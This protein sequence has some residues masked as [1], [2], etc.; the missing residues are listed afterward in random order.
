MVATGP[1]LAG[2]PVRVGEQLWGAGRWSSGLEEGSVK[3]DS[4]G[5]PEKDPPQWVM[6]RSPTGGQ[7]GLTVI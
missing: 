6:P 7:P 5:G 1:V 2:T 4:E 3:E